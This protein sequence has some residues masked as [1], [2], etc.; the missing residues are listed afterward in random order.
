MS[1]H[2]DCCLC[3][4]RVGIIK[5]RKHWYCNDCYEVF[6]ASGNFD[7]PWLD[8]MAGDDEDL[9]RISGTRCG[10]TSRIRSARA[11][12]EETTMSEELKPCTCTEEMQRRAVE[13][14]ANCD[15]CHLDEDGDIEPCAA[16]LEMLAGFEPERSV[17]VWPTGKFQ[18][19]D[20]PAP[21]D[22]EL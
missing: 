1:E 14:V 13:H 12:N 3:H 16:Y 6:V 21:K 18:H 17:A 19:Y 11:E 2:H 5:Y 20:V 9:E 15:E 8:H 7:D 22:G 10:T 4:E